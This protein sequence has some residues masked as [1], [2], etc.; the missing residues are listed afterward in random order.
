MTLSTS[1]LAS[2][3][4]VI[5][6]DFPQTFTWYGASYS[7]AVTDVDS[8]HTLESDGF[9]GTADLSITIKTSDFTTLPQ[10]N[11]KITYNSKDYRVL[12]VMHGQDGIS[13]TLNCVGLTK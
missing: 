4:S 3:L 13:K 5:F 8:S 6:A 10:A 11:Q 7:C 2:D 12:K 9:M 1:M